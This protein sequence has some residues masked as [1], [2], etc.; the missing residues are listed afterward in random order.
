MPVIVDIDEDWQRVASVG[1]PVVDPMILRCGDIFLRGAA[2]SPYEI[3]EQR[4][5]TKVTQHDVWQVL[6]VNLKALA[7]FFD[8]IVLDEKI[9]IFDYTQSF[10]VDP[11]FDRTSLGLVNQ[12]GDEVLVEV[13]VNYDIYS[14]VKAAAE[15]QLAVL[16]GPGGYS[17]TAD[18]A[19]KIL[20]ELATSGYTWYPDIPGFERGNALSIEQQR[21][22][23]RARQL[24]GYILAGL[25]F[26]AYAAKAGV[27]HLMQPK[28]SSLF[29]ATSFKKYG[30]RSEEQNLFDEFNNLPSIKK[31]E[32]PFTPT[33]FP[34][35][36]R[37]SK[38][39][40][41][42][43]AKALKLRK[44]SEIRE[45]RDWLRAVLNDFSR[46]GAIS[47]EVTSEVQSI[48]DGVRR[49]SEA[50]HFPKIEFTWKILELAPELSIEIN[51]AL[52]VPW[53]WFVERLPGKRYRKLLGRAL[54]VD[55]EYRNLER[56]ANTVWLGQG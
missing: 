3:L 23:E 30:P 42:M 41:E 39:P 4:G 40:Q 51:Q 31:A 18:E 48:L 38:N 45:Y 12:G 25:I 5:N 7:T 28:R 36:L 44:S 33:F 1:G 37:D 16:Y 2:V 49:K 26:G 52:E 46:N 11:S 54:I 17:P 15:E 14:K 8:R 32:I 43:I 53:G 13:Q 10:L 6:D 22:F 21:D 55:Y 35:L 56:R 24:A 27:D 20:G 34:L 29:L 50:F 9:P 47:M 19:D